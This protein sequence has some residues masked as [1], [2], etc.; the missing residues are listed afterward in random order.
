VFPICENLKK[1]KAKEKTQDPD[2][3]QK[4][5]VFADSEKQTK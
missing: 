4:C 3:H 5:A 2:R 1:N